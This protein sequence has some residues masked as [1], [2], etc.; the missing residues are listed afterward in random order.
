MARSNN[1][2]NKSKKVSSIGDIRTYLVGAV[3]NWNQQTSSL[4]WPEGDDSI[5]AMEDHVL[6]L[7]AVNAQLA[8]AEKNLPSDKQKSLA[9]Q[10][11]EASIFDTGKL[12]PFAAIVRMAIAA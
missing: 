12:A 7:R 11:D 3:K 6:M 4:S 2:K 5:A 9:A 8:L 1:D 10:F